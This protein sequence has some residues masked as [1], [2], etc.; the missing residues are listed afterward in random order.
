VIGILGGLLV[1][2]GGTRVVASLLFGVTARDPL[3]LIAAAA[4]LML[5]TV[6]A[7]YVPA[8]RASLVDPAVVL[9]TD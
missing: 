2:L 9:R 7:S 3:T 4:L 8:R 5:T 1:T 6:L